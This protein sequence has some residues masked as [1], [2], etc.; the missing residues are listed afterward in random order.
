MTERLHITRVR[1]LQ[2]LAA[3][4][5][6]VCFIAGCGS[7]YR[8]VGICQGLQTDTVND[9]LVAVCWSDEPSLANAVNRPEL[10]GPQYSTV[11]ELLDAFA[12]ERAT[13]PIFETGKERVESGYRYRLS[14][15][16]IV[17]DRKQYNLEISLPVGIDAG[18]M[19]GPTKEL[20]EFIRQKNATSRKVD[21][22]ILAIAQS[23][24]GVTLH[25]EDWK[26]R[27]MK[28]DQYVSK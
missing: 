6:V 9:R 20:I 7:T 15:P 10:L 1:K 8:S 18:A 24:F 5:H 21:L 25:V 23:K 4:G 13:L 28:V 22:D 3:I 16:A 26:I 11:D 12:A 2:Q 14:H 17:D 19:S 27:G